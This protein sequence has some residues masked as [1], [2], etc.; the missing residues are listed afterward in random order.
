M[1][2][3]H[4]NSPTSILRFGHARGDTTPPVGI[5]HRMWGA[6][7]HDAAT[8]I[9]RPIQ[10]DVVVLEPISG[11]SG[12]RVLRLQL[13]FVGLTNEQTD[14]L[15]ANLADGSGTSPDRIL[16]THSHSHSHKHTHTHR[17]LTHIPAELTHTHTHLKY[18]HS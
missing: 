16:V 17:E 14:R 18:T 15:V 8:G 9:H 12:D 6:A 2:T 3:T 7:R 11:L 1:S 4:I 5:Y 13:D 10:A